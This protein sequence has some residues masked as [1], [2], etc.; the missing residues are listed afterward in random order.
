ML[1]AVQDVFQKVNG[2]QMVDAM[3]SGFN[4]ARLVAN[5][6]EACESAPAEAK[7]LAEWFREKAGDR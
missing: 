7:L 6:L 3:E 1:D 2:G 5:E 4:A